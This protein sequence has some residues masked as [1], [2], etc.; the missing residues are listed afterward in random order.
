M[1]SKLRNLIMSTTL[2][3]RSFPQ[4]ISDAEAF[5][6]LFPSQCYSRWEV[7]GSTRRKAFEVGDVEH[8][9]IPNYGEIDRGGSL[10]FPQMDLVNLLWFHLEAIE[11][12][13]H[14][15]KAIYSDDK[16][17][18]GPKLRGIIFR[19]FRH[20]IFT[21]DADNFGSQLAIRTGPGDY[22]KMLVNAL[23]RNGFRNGGSYVRDKDLW[24]C[25]CG[26]TGDELMNAGPRW[27]ETRRP[28]DRW[29]QPIKGII[30][31]PDRPEE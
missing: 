13:E 5:R 23:Q 17:R 25:G 28:A 19:G 30:R 11:K 7:A 3:K 31:A 20:E 1:G 26:W 8:V 18:W 21:A 29:P 2:I 22:S 6:D 24:V 15:E 27:R 4:A 16:M 9:V 10:L 14:V 12:G